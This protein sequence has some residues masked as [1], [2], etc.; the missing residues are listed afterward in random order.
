[1]NAE[2]PLLDQVVVVTGAS[3]GIGRAIAVDFA[4]AGADIVVSARTTEAAPAELPG[5]IDET[6]RL[7]EAEGRRA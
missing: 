2:E 6:A 5:T 7:V 1:M 4:K 3:R